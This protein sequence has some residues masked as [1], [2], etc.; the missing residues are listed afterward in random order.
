MNIIQGHGKIE[1]RTVFVKWKRRWM[2]LQDRKDPPEKAIFLFKSEK[3]TKHPEKEKIILVNVNS[4]KRKYFSDSKHVLTLEYKD[5]NVEK[6][7]FASEAEL[8]G[9]YEQL[10]VVCFGSVLGNSLEKV[11]NTANEQNNPEATEV[12]E[13][14]VAKKDLFSVHLQPS[15]KLSISGDCELEV[16]TEEI[17]LFDVKCSNVKLVSWPIPSLRRFGFDATR[18]TFEAGRRC[19]TGE[20]M[21]VFKTKDGERIHQLVQ[22]YA[23]QLAFDSSKCLSADDSDNDNCI[24]RPLPPVPT[25]KPHLATQQ[26]LLRAVA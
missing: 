26:G 12:T 11:K 21:F 13:E 5:K 2:V 15:A 18:F 24:F 10:N 9:W 23:H 3:D 20:G 7:M 14:V 19:D 22:S 4:I 6:I 8:N 16:S 25:I 17:I 1:S